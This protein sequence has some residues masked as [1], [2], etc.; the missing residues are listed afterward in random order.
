MVN[1]EL[2]LVTIG[3]PT[4]NR[5]KYLKE[6]LES[7][8]NQTYPNIEIIVSDNTSTD[9][10][11]EMMQQYS[12]P[13]IK[14]FRHKENI[15]MVGN[16]NTCLEKANGRYFLLLSDDDILEKEAIGILIEKFKDKRI[17]MAYCNRIIIDE[18]GNETV[19]IIKNF[20]P[21]ELE[22]G[23]EFILKRFKGKS[24]GIPSSELFITKILLK[25]G[26]Y[27]LQTLGAADF[28]AEIIFCSEG[29]IAYDK[30]K[31]AKYRVHESNNARNLI[32]SLDSTIGLYN[33]I[34]KEDKLKIYKD[35]M[36][37]YCGS[38]V[39]RYARSKMSEFNLD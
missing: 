35:Q 26:G 6:A 12:N 10:T 34:Q 13:K 33:W 18:K 31:L 39:Y 38:V 28:A 25:Y 14:Y 1:E 4:Y 24:G 7:A 20:N 27:P 21:K 9:N 29:Y 30:H 11:Q 16:W 19:E 2:P 36:R 5:S 3:I 22:N 23:K 8:L 37:L 32:L 15:G 17:I